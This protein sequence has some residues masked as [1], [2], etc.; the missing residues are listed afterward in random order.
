MGFRHSL[1]IRLSFCALLLAAGAAFANDPHDRTQFG[2]DITIGPEE[3]ASD[4]TC[5]GCS[6]RVRGKVQTDVTTFGG[7][8]AVEDQGEIGGD[9][10]SFG[11]NVRLDKGARVSSITVFGGRI[12]RDPEATVNGDVTNFSG[13]I[14]LFLIFGLPFVF[15]GALIA[16]IVW[17]VRRFTRPT[18]PVAA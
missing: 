3:Q 1:L 7:G 14:W 18:M 4:V 8:I 6:V 9:T 17:L 15:L 13:S 11:G 10:T 12:H 5:F 16:L 2:H